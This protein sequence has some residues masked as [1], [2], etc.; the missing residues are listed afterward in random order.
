MAKRDKHELVC[1]LFILI[2]NLLN[3]QFQYKKLSGIHQEFYGKTW[4][5]SIDEQRVQI[6]LHLEMSSSLKPYFDSAIAEAFS[7]AVDLAVRETELPFKIFPTTCPY[8]VEQLLDD[9]FYPEPE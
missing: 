1:H 4:K 5:R 6:E 8:F 2:A 3:W 7:D 9:D